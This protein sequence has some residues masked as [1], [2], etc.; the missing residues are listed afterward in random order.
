ME[1]S[2][3]FLIYLLTEL[4]EKVAFFIERCNPPIPLKNLIFPLL[5]SVH[6]IF[7]NQIKAKNI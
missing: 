4:N 2:W 7:L 5:D 3:K 6:Q 1:F